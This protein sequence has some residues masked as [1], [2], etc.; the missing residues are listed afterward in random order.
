MNKYIWIFI[1]LISS[2][3][4]SDHETEEDF[5]A[6]LSGKDT[7][8]YDNMEALDAL[9]VLYGARKMQC[10]KGVS[11]DKERNAIVARKRSYAE[12]G[13]RER[14]V[15]ITKYR[16][17][18]NQEIK[19]T[20]KSIDVSTGSFHEEDCPPD[21]SSLSGLRRDIALFEVRFENNRARHYYYWEEFGDSK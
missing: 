3:Y 13:L 21:S 8:A 15:S 17:S 6:L 20:I 1:L 11:F 5:A 14:F 18:G 9:R 2:V 10:L 16:D 4:A 19:S 12:D 7:H